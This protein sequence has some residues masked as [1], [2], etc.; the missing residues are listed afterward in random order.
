VSGDTTL[1]EAADA[2]D[3]L[4]EQVPSGGRAM[5]ARFAVSGIGSGRT[6]EVSSCPGEADMGRRAKLLIVFRETA[7]L[8]RLKR[9]LNECGYSVE[10]ASTGAEGISRCG[11]AAF[12]AVVTHLRLPDMRGFEV[13]ARIKE[14]DATT[15]VIVIADRGSAGV[16]VEAIR[17]G[18]FYFI[19]EPFEVDCLR[20]LVER[21]LELRS[22]AAERRGL[23]D[24]PRARERSVA[25]VDSGSATAVRAA[26]RT[27]RREP[28]SDIV[29]RSDS[30]KGIFET[31][32]SVATSDANILITGE[33]GTGKELIANAIHL[34]SLRAK[35]SFVKINCAALPKELIEN[36]LFGHVRGAFTGAD[37]ETAGLIAA[38]RGGSLLLDEIA[39]LP[40]ELQPKLL[41]VLQERQYWRLGSERAVK[42][43]FRLISSTNRRPSDALDQGLLREDLYYRIA[44]ITIEVP[45]LRERPEDI[46]MLADHML[47]RFAG[48]YGKRITGF[49][50]A[51]RAAL[52]DSAWPGNVRQLENA[53]ERAVLLTRGTTIEEAVLPFLARVRPRPL[54]LA[55]EVHAARPDARPHVGAS[56]DRFPLARASAAVSLPGGMTLSQIE[57]AVILQELHRAKGNRAAA[58][59]ALGIYLPTLTEKIRGYC[60]TDYMPDGRGLRAV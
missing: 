9:S 33:S 47:K 4:V 21:A 22:L 48:K 13:L 5:S 26:A 40:L 39:E 51:A 43:D 10:T 36:E 41:R 6:T 28:F 19:E 45:P 23:G 8:E 54:A 14:V 55:E 56:V 7:M 35:H 24:T 32:E 34:E 27:T 44:T 53:I 17:A 50:S 52:L 57:R 1:E 29:G 31:I 16:A 37:R 42:A 18:A 15:E 2:A 11:R 49:S 58:A 46:E 12:D 25:V 30:M 20:L 60:L 3:Q 38:A 59:D